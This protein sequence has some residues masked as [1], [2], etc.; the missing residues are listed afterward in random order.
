MLRRLARVTRKDNIAFD[1][2]AR[3]SHVT[4]ATDWRVEYPLVVVN[5]AADEV[6]ELV[7][8]CMELRADHHSARRRHRQPPGAAVPL[9]P[10]SAVINT[11]S[12]TA[13]ARSSTPRCRRG[14][15]RADHRV[16]RAWSRAA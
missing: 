15:Q 12:W 9:T 6:P 7:R 10:L 5:P 8:A 3:V 14:G 4:D 2:F 16:A 1:G 11:E 13:S